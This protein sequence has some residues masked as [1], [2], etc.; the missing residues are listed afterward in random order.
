MQCKSSSHLF[1][2]KW[3]HFCIYYVWNLL[4]NIRALIIKLIQWPV[5]FWFLAEFQINWWV[6]DNIFQQT[7]WCRRVTLIADFS[8]HISYSWNIL[9][10]SQTRKNILE[11]SSI[12]FLIW[13][14]GS[15]FLYIYNLIIKI[16][17]N[18]WSNKIGLVSH[19][20][21]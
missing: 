2:K 3:S 10:L 20:L 7:L 8:I 1:G 14:S 4:L 19:Y 12:L 21:W 16:Y 6:E 15:P 18:F 17:S 9:T 5:I 13:I 11:L